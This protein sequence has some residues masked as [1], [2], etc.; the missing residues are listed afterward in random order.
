MLI[1]TVSPT[2]TPPVSMRPFQFRPNS[3][4]LIDV[5][6]LKPARSWP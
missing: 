1:L 3:R 6:A 2:I 4:R 5:W